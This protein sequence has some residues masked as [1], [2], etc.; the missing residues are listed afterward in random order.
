MKKWWKAGDVDSAL[1]P[2]TPEQ[3]EISA[4]SPSDKS[5]KM[6][7]LKSEAFVAE[8]PVPDPI[9]SQQEME[10]S[11]IPEAE[12]I[13][14]LQK[15]RPAQ[16]DLF[17]SEQPLTTTNRTV[18]LPSSDS[19]DLKP[20]DLVNEI[21]PTQPPTV[22]SVKS[23]EGDQ[24]RKWQSTAD[25]TRTMRPLN[26]AD[27]EEFPN[28]SIPD[29]RG[30]VPTKPWR[31][32]PVKRPDDVAEVPIPSAWSVD[33]IDCSSEGDALQVQVWAAS[34]RGTSH[35]I[36]GE[37]RQDSYSIRVTTDE[38][39]V[40]AAVGDGVGSSPLSEIGSRI[41]TEKITTAL[42]VSLNQINATEIANSD[43]SAF[44]TLIKKSFI[45]A[46]EAVIQECE[47]LGRDP[48]TD[49]LTTLIVAVV[50]TKKLT[51]D[52]ESPRAWLGWIGDS[53]IVSLTPKSN[54]VRRINE[55]SDLSPADGPVDQIPT[56]TLTTHIERAQFELIRLGADDALMLT[57]DGFGLAI[58]G[59]HREDVL[60]DICKFLSSELP[61]HPLEFLRILEFQDV[62]FHDDRTAVAIWRP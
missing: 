54:T 53:P 37:P 7:D 4:T 46:S 6:G 49:L 11:A 15:R 30:I 38:A 16:D 42:V 58:L 59:D 55:T 22:P 31:R 18:Q 39:W 20:D 29:E 52:G 57:S 14:T 36:Y 33:R 51:R 47:R 17:G 10:K 13:E 60:P 3:D 26:E 43:K 45:S 50:P 24:K 62:E 32:K 2:E 48:R 40:V 34:A 8:Q 19:T 5:L 41:A 23:G 9:T 25:E 27:R 56:E 61:Q 1:S 28:K 44:E 12:S 35:E 21:A